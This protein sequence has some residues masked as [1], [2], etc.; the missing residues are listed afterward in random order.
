MYPYLTDDVP[1][2]AA[3]EIEKFDRRF[4]RRA[5][6]FGEAL[7]NKLLRCGGALSEQQAMSVSVERLLL[8]VHDS[9]HMSWVPRLS[10][11]L[12]HLTQ[13]AATLMQL[14][15]SAASLS[16][17]ATSLR[18][19][20]QSGFTNYHQMLRWK[21]FSCTA[22]QK[23]CHRDTYCKPVSKWKKETHYESS[24]KRFWKSTSNQRSG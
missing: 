15:S 21:R 12:R 16:A 6:I 2:K 1:A 9:M 11:S 13:Y 10:M 18:H 22:R 8:S 17:S 14:D 24:R 7:N 5:M 4:R 20:R 3:A 23:T 19:A